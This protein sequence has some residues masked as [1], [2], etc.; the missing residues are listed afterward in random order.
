MASPL[1]SSP[2]RSEG[3]V[4]CAS[5]SSFSVCKE[6]SRGSPNQHQ[7]RRSLL[8]LRRV[9]HQFWPP[10]SSSVQT[11]HALGFPASGRILDSIFLVPVCFQPSSSSPTRAARHGRH[12]RAPPQCASSCWAT[13]NQHHPN[14]QRSDNILVCLY[15]KD[16]KIKSPRWSI[17]MRLFLPFLSDPAGIDGSSCVDTFNSQ[18]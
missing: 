17:K 8:Q 4:R 1:P 14:Q 6:S 9:I 16:P 15:P 3:T 18:Q 13:Q 12:A 10:S 5:S 2:L 7:N 11:E